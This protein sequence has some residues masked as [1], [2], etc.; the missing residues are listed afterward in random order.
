MLYLQAQVFS[1]AGNAKI[2]FV[3]QIGLYIIVKLLRKNTHTNNGRHRAA[4]QAWSHSCGLSEHPQFIPSKPRPCSSFAAFI[5]HWLVAWPNSLFVLL[6]GK[7]APRCHAL[8]PRFPAHEKAEQIK[9][10]NEQD[11]VSLHENTHPVNLEKGSEE[12]IKKP[13]WA[14]G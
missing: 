7:H 4:L 1:S 9:E 6:C 5:F 8:E 14:W 3:F 10:R 12:R 11:V 2:V 13:Q